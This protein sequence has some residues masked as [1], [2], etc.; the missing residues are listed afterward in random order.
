MVSTS[1]LAFR[2]RMAELA[3][4]TSPSIMVDS[5]EAAQ[6]GWQRTL[7]VMRRVSAELGHA[8]STGDHCWVDAGL[9]CILCPAGWCHD[10][11]TGAVVAWHKSQFGRGSFAS[12]WLAEADSFP[13][14]RACGTCRARSV[15]R[16]SHA[17]TQAPAPNQTPNRAPNSWML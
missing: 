4:A 11:L 15:S 17:I 16:R 8:L 14:Q 5:W 10:G 9:S 2:V 3:A 7:A 12:L 6:P 13:E 1:N